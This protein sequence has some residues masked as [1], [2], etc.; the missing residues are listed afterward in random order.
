M[1]A[2]FATLLAVI[3]SL[4]IA[5]AKTTDMKRDSVIVVM[6]DKS[7]IIIYGENKEELKKLMK[8]DI[9]RLLK[10]VGA[11]IDSTSEQGTTKIVLGEMDGTKYA[12]KQNA[13]IRITRKGIEIE[14]A[15]T[16]STGNKSVK[17]LRPSRPWYKNDQDNFVLSL[18][19][20]VYG[21]N[22]GGSQYADPN[23]YDLRP[24]GS[25]YVS[26]GFYRNPAIIPGQNVALRLKLGF[27]FSWYNLMFE[28]NNVATKGPDRIEF[29]ESTTP[30]KKSK[31]TACYFNIPV[32]PTIA[33]RKGIVS[34]I[35]IGGYAG[36]RIDSYT[37]TKT[38]GGK[39]DHKHAGYWLEN[40]RYGVGAELGFRNSVD[41]FVQYDL[42]KLYQANRGPEVQMVS[43]GVRFN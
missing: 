6:G 39:K 3:G 19:L 41:L 20:N 8:Y 35:A 26:L 21:K 7:R 16:D 2:V 33:F 43:F 42:N 32:M 1:K 14:T 37:K 22:D 5:S 27:D 34:H 30:L 25:R 40:F 36:Y 11:K 24:L 31:L 10:D 18:G 9:N 29:P 13:S 17:R 4:G 23:L 15:N 12:A 28:G 38:E